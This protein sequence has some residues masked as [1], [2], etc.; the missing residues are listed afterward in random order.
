[1]NQNIKYIRSLSPL[2]KGM[3]F[4]YLQNPQ[5]SAYFEQLQ[6]KLTGEFDPDLFQKSFQELIKR[7][8]ALRSLF[9]YEQ[10]KEPRQVVLRNRRAVQN[11]IDLSQYDPSDQKVRLNDIISADRQNLFNISTDSLIRLIIVRLDENK[12]HVI[13][14]FHHIILDGWSLGI[15]LSELFELYQTF[16]QNIPSQLKQSNSFV[17]YHDWIHEQ[18]IQSGLEYWKSCLKD[19]HTITIVPGMQKLSESADYRKSELK[20]TIDKKTTTRLKLLCDRNQVTMNTLIQTIWGILLQRYN[21]SNDVVFGSVVSGRHHEIEHMESMVGLFINTIPVRIQSHSDREFCDL[22]KE[23]QKQARHSEKYQ[24]LSLADIQMQTAVKS[25]LITHIIAFENYAGNETLSGILYEGQIQNLKVSDFEIYEHTHYDFNLVVMPSDQI[26]IKMIFNA[27]RIHDKSVKRIPSHFLKAIDDVLRSDTDVLPIKKIDIISDDEREFLL[28]QLNNTQSEYPSDQSIQSL[29]KECCDVNAS[30]TAL[31]YGEFKLT[32]HELDQWSNHI[33]AVLKCKNLNPESI[34]PLIVNRSPEYVAG[35]LGILKAGY[36]YLPLADNLPPTRLIELLEDC[37]AECILTNQHIDSDL[38]QFEVIPLT[39]ENIEK[40]DEKSNFYRSAPRDLAYVMYTSGSTGKPKGVMVEHRSVIRLVK[41][42]N[43]IDFYPEDQILLTGAVSFDATTFEVWGALLNGLTLHLVDETILLDPDKLGSYIHHHQITIL[44]LTASL[45]TQMVN[46][47]INLFQG[48][49]V[50]LAGGDVLSTDHVNQLIRTYPQ[51][52]IINGYGPTENTTFS[53]TYLIERPLN[54][55][56]PIGTPIAN[57]TAFV[58]NAD[59]KLVP[60]GCKGEL[61]VGGDG[62]ARGYFNLPDLTAERF[63]NHPYLNHERLYRTGDIVRLQEDGCIEFMGR[64][65]NQI[66]IRGF[67]IELGEIEFNLQNRTDLKEATVILNKDTAGNKMLVAFVVPKENFDPDLLKSELNENLPQYMVPSQFFQF[68]RLPLNQNG[69]VDKKA[70]TE[71]LND[72]QNSRQVLLPTN[73]SEKYLYQIWKENLNINQFSIEDNFYDLGGNSISAIQIQMQINDAYSLTLND[74]FKYPTVKLLSDYLTKKNTS[75]LDPYECIVEQF[76]EIQNK[77]EKFELAEPVFGKQMPSVHTN[78]MQTHS[79]K[80]ILLTGGTGFLGI[81]LLYDFL[82]NTNVNCTCIVRA[83]SNVDA[84]IRIKEKWGYYFPDLDYGQYQHRVDV[85]AGDL[86]QPMMGLDE[87]I[88]HPLTL[89]V[90][91]ILN[92]AANVKHFGPYSEFYKDNVQSVIHLCEFAMTGHA[93]ILHHVST[94]SVGISKLKKEGPCVFSED[95]LFLS[96]DLDY[97]YIKSKIEA[98]NAIFNQMQK[99][100][101]AH[102]YRVGN[103]VWNSVSG[104]FQQ[105]KESN[106]FYL[107]LKA[108]YELKYFPDIRNQI[109]DLS[110]VD[111]TANAIVTAITGLKQRQPIYHIYNSC[112]FSYKDLYDLF[113][114]ENRDLNLL[115]FKEFIDLL[116]KTKKEVNETILRHAPYITVPFLYGLKTVNKKTEKK[117]NL[118]WDPIQSTQIQKFIRQ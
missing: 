3:L 113:S 30:K 35:M 2:Q 77:L 22:L 111:I 62:L 105:N 31:V 56:I 57:S 101:H 118:D 7:H 19:C 82:V 100:L 16:K 63:V 107:S 29:F 68:D 4:T 104:K 92:S 69:K 11:Q 40:H 24:Y 79:P 110:C 64:K 112:L 23:V 93:K 32:Y 14:S 89:A 97:P 98:E 71:Y 74:F 96:A 42:T 34:V 6:F 66:K 55:S 18:N 28:N 80:N 75:A 41:N 53:T 114:V 72:A 73:D 116:R 106:A 52:K 13:I 25:D 84:L 51:L 21:D 115:K 99:G 86:T 27:N 9:L 60:V 17:A 91:S 45:F 94:L 1:M 88:Y 38:S 49:R 108:L 10:V 67:R 46:L 43:Y 95:D 81:H 36:A 39:I 117:L 102:I 12:F 87:E 70:L 59:R 109:I 15:V 50:L 83:R 8:D 54:T 90:D 37:K 20:F 103:L 47:N 58:M 61:F 33:A 76:D 78:P 48:L 5:S 26:E 44:W 65:D 85:I